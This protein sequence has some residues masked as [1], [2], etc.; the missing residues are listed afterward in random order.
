MA[1]QLIIRALLGMA[2]RGPE[3]L[4][5]RGWNWLWLLLPLALL[6][7]ATAAVPVLSLQ[8]CWKAQTWGQVAGRGLSGLASAVRLQK[9]LKGAFM[10]A[11][12]TGC[13]LKLLVEDPVRL[14]VHRAPQIMCQ[15]EGILHTAHTLVIRI[16][17]IT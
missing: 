8:Y 14:P 2:W 7:E 17:V 9:L 15:L 4:Q 10:I 11:Q 13:T 16:R 1:L 12:H 3:D 6:V 5:T